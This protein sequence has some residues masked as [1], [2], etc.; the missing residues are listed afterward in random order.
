MEAAATTPI[1]RPKRRRPP[2]FGSSIPKITTR[3]LVTSSGGTSIPDITD[4]EDCPMCK[5]FG[6]GPCGE[7]FKKWLAC[8]DEHPGKDAAGEPLHLSNCSDFAEK[9]AVC[10]DTNDEYY[11]KNDDNNKQKHDANNDTETDQELKDAWKDFVHSMEAGIASGEYNIL[12]YPENINPKM[13]VRLANRTGAAFFVPEK[14]GQPLIAAYILDNNG[15]VIAAGSKDDMDM[16]S[17]GCVLQFKVAD[18]MKSATS[19][20]IYDNEKDDIDIFSRTM[21]LPR[22]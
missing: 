9:L 21:L 22:K 20:A 6:S 1:G 2:I 8:T 7:V 18:G 12:P 17:L 14:D 11:S 16:G 13:E 10:L 4:R 15:S 5:K 19:R 3:G